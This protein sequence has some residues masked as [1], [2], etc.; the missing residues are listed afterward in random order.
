VGIHYPTGQIDA[1]NLANELAARLD[2]LVS[3]AA[4]PFSQPGQI[5]AGIPAS[6]VE[7]IYVGRQQDGVRSTTS[8][9]WGRIGLPTALRTTA[10]TA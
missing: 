1:Q 7:A 6:D 5:G 2:E 9:T 8:R 10:S 4:S 3:N